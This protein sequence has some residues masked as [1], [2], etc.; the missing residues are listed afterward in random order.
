MSDLAREHSHQ[1]SLLNKPFTKGLGISHADF[2]ERAEVI[3][4]TLGASIVGENIVMGYDS[5][6]SMVEAWMNSPGHKENILDP[7]FRR[8]GIGSTG[9]FENSIYTQIFSD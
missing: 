8:T 5:S 9:F 3:F 6:A 1:Q 4:S 2:D 7:E